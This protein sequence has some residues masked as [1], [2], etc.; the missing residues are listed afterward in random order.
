MD[1]VV[2]TDLS[3]LEGVLVSTVS[4]PSIGGVL[5]WITGADGGWVQAITVN[6]VEYTYDRVTDTSSIP[7]AGASFNNITNEW[8]ITTPA[9]SKLIVDMDDG[10]YSYIPLTSATTT[11][12]ESFGYRVVDGD[13]DTA[14]STL[15][16]QVN[17]AVE[18]LVVRDNR[19]VTNQTLVEIPIWALLAND[20]GAAV[21]AI[22]E[23]SSPAAGDTVAPV[24]PGAENITY[25]D[26][27]TNGGSFIYTNTVGAVSVSAN[28]TVVRDTTSGAIDGNYLDD[29]LIGG[30]GNETLNAGDD[31]LIG[32][33]G[34]DILNGGEGNDILVGGVGDDTL[35]G[36]AGN[37]TLYGGAGNDT[38]NGGAGNDVMYG[39][40]GND[41]YIVDSAGD[42][43]I[44]AVGEGTDTV[45]AS[46]SYVLGSNV[47]N[48]TLTG[49]SNLNGTGN[50]LDN[51]ITGNG[52]NNTLDGGKRPSYTALQLK[53]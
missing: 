12:N 6:G 34:N 15:N 1:A 29:I 32:N 14:S 51:L 46:I 11:I 53:P 42:Q 50:E 3:Q 37:D 7:T 39:G 30:S 48:L 45:Q 25:N 38:L 24:L 33:A 31:I 23:V 26:A 47:E 49:S 22:T 21:H 10:A 44:E 43:V 19:V 5:P 4:V 27:N 18:P 41:T 36:D 52:G 16:I 8:T 40:T 13:G 20:T 17:S 2:V 35:N 28:V 9:G